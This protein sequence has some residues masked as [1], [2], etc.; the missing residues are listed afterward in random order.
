MKD[1]YC[2]KL[3]HDGKIISGGAARN[4]RIK[5]AGGLENIIHHTA[6]TAAFLTAQAIMGGNERRQGKIST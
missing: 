4:V 3:M 2:S 1:K 5:E 6:Q